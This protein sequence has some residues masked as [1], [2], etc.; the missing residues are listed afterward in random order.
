VVGRVRVWDCEKKLEIETQGSAICSPGQK[1]YLL[2][3]A[4]MEAVRGIWRFYL[5]PLRLLAVTHGPNPKDFSAPLLAEVE[6]SERHGCFH[7]KTKT[8]GG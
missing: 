3:A 4:E 1:A 6:E 8:G 2:A 5:F 7:K